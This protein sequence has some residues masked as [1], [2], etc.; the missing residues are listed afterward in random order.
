MKPRAYSQENQQD[1]QTT[2]TIEKQYP[3]KIRN[4]KGDITTDT[5]KN[6]KIHQVLLPKPVLHKIGKSQGNEQ[7]FRQIPLSKVKSRT[8]K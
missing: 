4:Q 1:R 5:E 3:N 8:D 2:Q 6:S 7:F